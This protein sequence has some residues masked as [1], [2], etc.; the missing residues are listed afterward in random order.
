[1]VKAKWKNLRDRFKKEVNKI[2]K[3]HSGDDAE[4]AF[5]YT[6]SWCHFEAMMFLKCIVTP[7]VTEG[8]IG[9]LEKNSQD[10]TSESTQL[11]QHSD[12]ENENEQSQPGTSCSQLSTNQNNPMSDQP[13]DDGDGVEHLLPDKNTKTI[14]V[15]VPRKRKNQRTN[16]TNLEE[17]F[18]KLEAKKVALLEQNNDDD[19]DI[20]FFKSL[21]PHVRQL[22][23]INKLHFRSQ[24]QNLLATE[25]RRLQDQRDISHIRTQQQ[26]SHYT[27][28]VTSPSST[29]S[30]CLSSP[31]TPADNHNTQQQYLSQPYL[32][33]NIIT[34]V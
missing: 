33:E 1:M 19:E 14:P 28:N 3:P 34:Y 11:H 21:L 12:I 2:P 7:K 9:M 31:N 26:F 15:V 17:E 29:I 18:L 27:S 10:D 22:P 6:G 13:Q 24:V 32:N 5:R 20:N 4:S 8:N 23:S 30:P 25:I 16:D